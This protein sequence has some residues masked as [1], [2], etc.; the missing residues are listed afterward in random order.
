M[1]GNNALFVSGNDKNNKF[2][3]KIII[4]VLVVLAV[5]FLVGGF[6]GDSSDVLLPDDVIKPDLVQVYFFWS[7]TCSHCSDE[8]PFIEELKV[9]YD[10]LQ[11]L[12]YEIQFSPDN[13][14]LFES[15][16]KKYDVPE[17]WGVPAVFVG[18]EHFIGYSGAIAVDIEDKVK[19]EIGNLGNN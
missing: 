10:K 1:G 19:E 12:D 15:F 18:D 13:N 3:T 7:A 17:P 9:K 5:I 14:A 16:L 11:V 8:K 2:V 6:S 4:L